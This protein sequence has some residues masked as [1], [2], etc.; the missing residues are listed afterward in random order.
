MPKAP[1]GDKLYTVFI[2][3]YRTLP[4][5]RAPPLHSKLNITYLIVAKSNLVMSILHY[6]WTTFIKN[7]SF[8]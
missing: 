3:N 8:F 1:A 7:M 4:N 2:Y 6:F 5:E